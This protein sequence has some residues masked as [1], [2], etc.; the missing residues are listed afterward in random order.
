MGDPTGDAAN[1]RCALKPKGTWTAVESVAGD[2]LESNRNPVEFC[3]PT[4]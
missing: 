2:R 4:S 1:G 3:V